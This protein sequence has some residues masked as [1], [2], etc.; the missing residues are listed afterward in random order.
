MTENK[1]IE[2]IEEAQDLKT[3]DN[4]CKKDGSCC[5]GKCLEET[6]C[7]EN[8]CGC[9]DVE[10]Y[11]F[12]TC[13]KCDC[14]CGG[15]ACENRKTFWE[16]KCFTFLSGILLGIVIVVAINAIMDSYRYH[17]YNF[18]GYHKSMMIDLR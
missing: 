14:L 5:G 10:D 12:D 4:V 2:N 8:G 11:D 9:D 3:E 1:K 6:C 7:D 13:K 16:T 17:K 18:S 15:C